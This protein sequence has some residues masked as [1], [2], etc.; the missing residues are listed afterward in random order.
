[1]TMPY[2]EIQLSKLIP[3]LS[4]IV[5]FSAYSSC[6]GSVFGV[7]FICN[8]KPT[9][10]TDLTDVIFIV[11]LMVVKSDLLVATIAQSACFWQ[12]W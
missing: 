2:I 1:M 4:G 5:C 6:H 10:C 7:Y 11:H 8:T 12:Q 3:L 9:L